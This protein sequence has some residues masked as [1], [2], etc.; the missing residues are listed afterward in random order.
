MRS[1]SAGNEESKHPGEG[2]VERRGAIRHVR[3][4]EFALCVCVCVYVGQSV[5]THFRS[6]CSRP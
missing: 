3:E 6:V 5:M 2:V 4:D 1:E